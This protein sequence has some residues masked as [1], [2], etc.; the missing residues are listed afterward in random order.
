[1]QDIRLGD[2]GVELVVETGLFVRRR[3]M[4]G[5]DDVEAILPDAYQ[6]VVRASR[7]A[8]V[9]GGAGEIET[10]GGIVRMP[11]HDAPRLRRAQKEAA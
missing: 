4:I 6:I 1:V 7:R 2:E 9:L 3:F 5:A 8:A 10:A 11:I